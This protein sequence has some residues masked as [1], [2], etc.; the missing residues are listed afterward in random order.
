MNKN[1]LKNQFYDKLRIGFHHF[2]EDVLTKSA[3]EIFDR[4]LEIADKD[5]ILS[6]FAPEDDNFSKE[7]L[8][9]FN[10]FKKPLDKLFSIWDEFDID[11]DSLDDMIECF[12]KDFDISSKSKNQEDYELYVENSEDKDK[13]FVKDFLSKDSLIDFFKSTSLS[14]IAKN[15]NISE[16]IRVAISKFG[17]VVEPIFDATI[18]DDVN[19]YQK[20]N[21]NVLSSVLDKSIHSYQDNLQ[22]N[23]IDDKNEDLTTVALKYHLPQEIHVIEDGE[24]QV[25]YLDAICDQEPGIFDKPTGIYSSPDD[26]DKWLDTSTTVSNGETSIEVNKDKGEELQSYDINIDSDWDSLIPTIL[27]TQFAAGTLL[28]ASKQVLDGIE[29]GY[30]KD[31]DLAEWQEALDSFKIPQEETDASKTLD[32]DIDL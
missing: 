9:Y 15:L 30:L 7:E 5:R 2:K 29:N 4:A 31:A 20:C 1:E 11:K 13:N 12:H 28:Y 10:S 26:S 16:K 3:E 6:A 22:I 27:T 32:K 8:E 25:Y 17:E 21:D 24:I 23:K 14:S 19:Y 18:G